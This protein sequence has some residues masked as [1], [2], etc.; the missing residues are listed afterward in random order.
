M[1]NVKSG[2]GSPPI[3][4]GLGSLPVVGRI[5]NRA[6]KWYA[7]CEVPP[8]IY[9]GPRALLFPPDFVLS[10]LATRSYPLYRMWNR[11]ADV[12]RVAYPKTQLGEAVSAEQFQFDQ[13]IVDTLRA[14]GVAT[15]P[16]AL[17]AELLDDA[18]EWILQRF[19]GLPERAERMDG[20]VVRWTDDDGVTTFLSK[21]KGR[22]RF[23]FP[24]DP[25]LL[26]GLPPLITELT[27]LPV[28]HRM[29]EA[30]YGMAV[31]GGH[32]YV[33]AEVAIPS[34]KIET[35]H[36][37]CLRSGVKAFLY[38]NDVTEAQGPLRVLPG[39]HVAEGEFDR[40]IYRVGRSGLCEAYYDDETNARMDREGRMMVGPANTMTLFNTRG[41]HAG[42]YV[43]EG[44]RIALVNG[45]R[46]ASSV[47][48]NP[49][50]FPNLPPSPHARPDIEP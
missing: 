7:T 12:T 27:R 25:D 5:A 26:R 13:Q 2:G 3:N 1:Q 37:D 21:S 19:E 40:Q 49:R 35:W 41:R 8:G 46:P 14:D 30:H 23:I 43:R 10:F 4:S 50:F 44:M 16:N 45:F 15:I 31:E 42:Y 47:R 24:K 34:E 11:W 17:P 6:A 36:I 33:M 28:T 18:R 22:Y 32:P 38:L 48:I 39:S 29:V 9:S 20:D